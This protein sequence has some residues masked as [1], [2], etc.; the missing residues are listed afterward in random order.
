M[1]V[2]QTIISSCHIKTLQSVL[3]QGKAL[4]IFTHTHAHTYKVESAAI[5]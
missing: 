1:Q 4:S 2:L 3:F 5:T